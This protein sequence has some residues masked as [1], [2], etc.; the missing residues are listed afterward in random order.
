MEFHTVITQCNSDRKKCVA[1]VGRN[2]HILCYTVR[3]SRINLAELS[4]SKV[5]C[6]EPNEHH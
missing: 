4:Q 5:R 1:R 2:K 6:I 3:I